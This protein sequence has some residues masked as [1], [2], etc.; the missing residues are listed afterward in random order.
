MKFSLGS[1]LLF[2]PTFQAFVFDGHFEALPLDPD[3]SSLLLSRCGPEVRCVLVNSH[4]MDSP[5]IPHIVWG[6]QYFRY[7][8]AQYRRFYIELKGDFEDYMKRFSSTRRKHLKQALKYFTVFSGG[9][10]DWREYRNTGDM[11]EFHQHAR[12]ISRKT[13]QELVADS[14]IPDGEAF[15]GKLNQLAAE[16]R[17]RGYV[18]FHDQQPVAYQFWV[19]SNGTLECKFIG[20]DPAYREYAPGN[21]L[22]LL[23]VERAFATKS[24]G[25]LD[26]GKAEYPY[27]ETF[28]S[29]YLHCADIYYF[30]P[31]F[32]N[33][34]LISGHFLLN[35][36]SMSGGYL[37]DGLRL[38]APIRK[39]VRKRRAKF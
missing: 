23:T 8:P 36:V 33:A 15:T 7:A 28:S 6:R 31:T 19:V 37:L 26:L 17:V 24:F 27:K 35:A 1:L 5:S 3:E 25:R 22:L 16:D 14:G 34:L 9:Q 39:L 11:S 21:V 38:R 2:A 10:V 20:Y 13:Y 29:G 18:L 12:E 32:A 30:R 4:P